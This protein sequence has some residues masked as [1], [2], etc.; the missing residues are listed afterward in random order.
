MVAFLEKLRGAD[1][2]TKT[3][4]IIVVTSVI[5]VIVIYIWLA[6]FNTLLAPIHGSATADLPQREESTAPAVQP[7]LSLAQRMGAMYHIFIDKIGALGN[8]FKMQREY[9]IKPN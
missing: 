3:K 5:M 6:Y 7:S 2:P 4:W 1:E 9:I 8:I